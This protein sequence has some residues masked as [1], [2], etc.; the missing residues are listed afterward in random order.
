VKKTWGALITILIVII[1]ILVFYKN[2]T[3]ISTLPVEYQSKTPVG[4]PDSLEWKFQITMPGVD[5]VPDEELQIV[6]MNNY[7]PQDV[8]DHFTATYGT[9]VVASK[10]T[11][12]EEQLQLLEKFPGKY[13]ILTT[14]DY[15]VTKMIGSGLLHKLDRNQLPNMTNLDADVL[16]AD[17]DLGLGYSVPLFRTSLGVVF[18]INYVSGIP[19]DL[20]FVINQIY[21]DYLAF[22]TGFIKEMRFA[23]GISLMSLG[24]SPNTIISAQIDE[25][26]DRLITMINKYGLTFMDEVNDDEALIANEILLAMHWNGTAATALLKNSNINFLLPEGQVLVTIDSAVISAESKRIRTAQLFINYLL[27]PEVA[28]RMSNYNCFAN[29]ITASKPFVRRIISNGP[30]FIFPEE[31]DRLF[32][33]DLGENIKMYDD[34]WAMVLDAKPSENLVRLPLPKGGLF[35]GGSQSS[36]FANRAEGD[37]TTKKTQ[38]Q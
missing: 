18:N 27:I 23:M 20:N 30:G 3:Q 19:R 9:R 25:A 34:A 2:R 4:E 16:R 12:N 1:C 37:I 33:R 14:G 29:C 26:R 10:V 36:D 22:R 6:T 15:M 8:Y 35:Q 24:Y 7:I 28:A 11:S 13:D 32:L 38:S 21:N 5:F 31:G 17:Y